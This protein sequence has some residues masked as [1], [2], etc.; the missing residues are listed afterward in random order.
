VPELRRSACGATEAAGGVVVVTGA[1]AICR[2]W[3]G[4]TRPEDAD[5]YETYLADELYP[6]VAREL[7]RRGYLGFHVLRRDGDADGEVEF[8]TMTWF[9]SLESVRSFAGPSYETPVLTRA[10]RRLL[11]RHD[12]RASHYELCASEPELR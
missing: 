7:G 10:A 8:V 2:L 5:A 11:S 6:R 1:G 4:W 9:D 12:E 3:H